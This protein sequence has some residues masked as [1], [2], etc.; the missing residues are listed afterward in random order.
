MGKSKLA[1]CSSQNG[2]RGYQKEWAS[3]T[4]SSTAVQK[5]RCSLWAGCGMDDLMNGCGAGHLGKEGGERQG[6]EPTCWRQLS[7]LPAGWQAATSRQ[8]AWR[9]SGRGVGRTHACDPGHR[10]WPLPRQ[11]HILHIFLDAFL[12]RK[13]TCRWYRTHPTTTAQHAASHTRVLASPP[14]GH[15]G[16]RQPGLC[17]RRSQHSKPGPASSRRHVLSSARQALPL[18]RP[19][20]CPSAHLLAEVHAVLGR[21]GHG[22]RGVHKGS[23]PGARHGCSSGRLRACA[24][25][26]HTCRQPLAMATHRS[27]VTEQ[28]AFTKCGPRQAGEAPPSPEVRHVK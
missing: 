6:A 27:C 7:F 3:C 5:Y 2:M 20:A 13:L 15:A 9:A 17:P 22:D 12:G 8:A 11:L 28:Q 25:G 14:A 10:W 1:A 23:A 21:V 24:R 18:G 16:G 19:P 4:N 26:R